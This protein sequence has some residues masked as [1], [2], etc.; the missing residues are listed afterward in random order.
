MSVVIIGGNER[1]ASRYEHICNDYGYK[2]KV[3]TKENGSMKRKLGNPDM[4]IVF[5]NTVSHKM[6]ISAFQ[7]AKKNNV[8]IAKVHA[9]SVS[10]LQSVLSERCNGVKG[11]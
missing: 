8:P 11:A 5:M 3:Y 6:V 4:L 2:A 9:G 10:A 1:M 7:E